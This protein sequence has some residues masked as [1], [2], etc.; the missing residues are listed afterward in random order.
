MCEILSISQ[1]DEMLRH[2]RLETAIQV[3]SGPNDGNSVELAEYIRLYRLL[4][5]Q[6][7]YGW[8]LLMFAIRQNQINMV[9]LL[10]YLGADTLLSGT[11]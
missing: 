9:R 2:N 8:T 10:L 5:R 1:L 7:R 6:D 11:I 4:N 3:V